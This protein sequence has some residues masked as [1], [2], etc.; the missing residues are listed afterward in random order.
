MTLFFI[1]FFSVFF[2]FSRFI[3]ILISFEFMMMG[4]FC[5][6]SFFFGFFSFFYFLCFSV[7]CSL[8]GVV[9]MVYFV[10]FYGSD[11]VFF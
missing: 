7:F 3:F 11:Y 9:L 4:I 10:K 2:K 6:F 8:F 1:G 5:V